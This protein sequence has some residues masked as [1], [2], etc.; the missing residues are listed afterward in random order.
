MKKLFYILCILVL[1]GSVVPVS[2]AASKK[3]LPPKWVQLSDDIYV[4]VNS[5]TK[6]KHNIVSAWFLI[7]ASEDNN[8]YEV[9]DI[10]VYYEIIKRDAYCNEDI[11]DIVHVKSFDK[12][13]RIL[14]DEPDNYNVFA[15]YYETKNG[16]IYFNALC[17][18]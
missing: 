17:S 12:N 7:F 10:P 11:V 3:N 9:D 8:L 15:S 16:E 5:I 18:K 2:L 13:G 6:G 14:Q 4:D 1:L